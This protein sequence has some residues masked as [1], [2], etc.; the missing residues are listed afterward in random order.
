MKS[1][2]ALV[3]FSD[4]GAGPRYIS[5]HG[6]SVVGEAARTWM[7]S[8]SAPLQYGPPPDVGSQN[9]FHIS[10]SQAYRAASMPRVLQSLQTHFVYT[11]QCNGQSPGIFLALFSF[12]P[13]CRVTRII[14]QKRPGS[15]AI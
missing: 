13:F 2:T 6:F 9:F 15:G 1:V 5:V 4:S 10:V 12:P 14:H 11:I 8:Q 7:R 3:S